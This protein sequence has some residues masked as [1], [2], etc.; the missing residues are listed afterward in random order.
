[1]ES[2]NLSLQKH[3]KYFT[4]LMRGVPEQAHSSYMTGLY[5]VVSGLV[6]L[7]GFDEEKK[8]EVV[9]WIYAQQVEFEPYAGFRANSSAALDKMSKWD[10][11]SLASTYSA[12]CILHLMGDDFSRVNKKAIIRSI[13]QQITP[14]GSVRSH[15]GS[16][17]NDVRFVY[18][19]C[20]ICY[21]LNDWEGVDKELLTSFILSCQTYESGFSIYPGFEAHGG[22]TYCALSS[23]F[24]MG[25]LDQV[26]RKSEL[27]EWLVMRQG[28]GFCG[29]PGKA[30]DSCYGYWIGLSLKL[31]KAERFI[32]KEN[33]EFYEEC[34]TPYGGLSKYPG[35]GKPDLTHSYLGLV[36][37]SVLKVDGLPE[38]F[39]ALGIVF[40]SERG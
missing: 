20:S 32:A 23:L 25:R 31:L 33:L 35:I 15:N 26:P 30:E 11:A 19:L 7:D 2:L 38:V 29:R 17:E 9:D 24:L 10:Y 18:C 21:L 22:G 34:E 14:T 6:V 3:R 36:A 12:L 39:P 37:L 1:M 28:H 5:F 8:A 16:S 13:Q 4:S 40:K 27:I